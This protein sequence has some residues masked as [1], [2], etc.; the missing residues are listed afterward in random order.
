VDTDALVGTVQSRPDVYRF[1]GPN[2]LRFAADLADEE[3]RIDFVT[4]L[5]DRLRGDSARTRT[6]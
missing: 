5:L 2:G 6:E 1:D 3:K 4:D